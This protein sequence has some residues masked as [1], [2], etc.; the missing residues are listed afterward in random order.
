MCRSIRYVPASLRKSLYYSYVFSHVNYML[1]I[2]GNCPTYKLSELQVLQNRCLKSLL[3]VPFRTS[4]TY[5]YSSSLLPIRILYEN[6]CVITV[7]KLW[8]NCMNHNFN[9]TTNTEFHGRTT[10]QSNLIRFSDQ[11]IIL[12]DM[13]SL[14]SNF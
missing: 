9:M 8:S 1:P 11:H 12:N 10:R 7:F 3:C 5:L 6:Q 13:I 2:Y 4:T 14:H